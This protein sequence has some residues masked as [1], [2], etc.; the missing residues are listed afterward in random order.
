MVERER[1]MEEDEEGGYLVERATRLRELARGH[2]GQAV[3]VALAAGF[4]LGIVLS[5]VIAG[6]SRRRTWPEKIAS[7]GYLRR[8]LEAVERHLPESISKRLND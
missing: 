2:E 8:L 5:T 6:S 1:E 7:E 3:V 4:S